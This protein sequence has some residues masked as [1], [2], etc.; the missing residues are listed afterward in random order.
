V[1]Q[2][3]ARTAASTP[4]T[5]TAQQAELEQE[6]R[7][8]LSF[9]DFVAERRGGNTPVLDLAHLGLGPDDHTAS[10]VPDDPVLDV[11][12]RDV[13]LTGPPPVWRTSRSDDSP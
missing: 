2:E 4:E 13:A 1:K 5:V 8:L 9:L 6:E 12:D 3:I 7:R 11:V 10:L